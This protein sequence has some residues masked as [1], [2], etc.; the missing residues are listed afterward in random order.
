VT[1][2]AGGEKSGFADGVGAHARLYCPEGLL[3]SGDG[4]KLFVA[5]RYQNRVRLIHTDTCAVTTIAG[6][7]ELLSS[8]GVPRFAAISRPCALAFDA[9]AAIPESVLHI[10]CDTGVMQLT[11]ATGRALSFTSLPPL[12][13]LVLYPPT[14]VCHSQIP[15]RSFS[16][17]SNPSLCSVK[18]CSPLRCG[19]SWPS[20]ARAKVSRSLSQH[21]IPCDS[22]H[23][24]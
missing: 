16:T 11:F 5:D 2:I 23:L 18:T 14:S 9:A 20:T 12:Q 3:C 4:S 7:G 8:E 10:T 1:L 21:L 6:T 19:E 15:I 24:I 17:A 13:G 22:S